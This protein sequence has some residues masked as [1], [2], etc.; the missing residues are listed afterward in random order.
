MPMPMPM[1]MPTSDALRA[2]VAPLA[3]TGLGPP[4]AADAPSPS[5]VPLYRQIKNLIIRGLQAGDWAPGAA[6][7]SESEL[8]SRYKVS[9]GT[10]RKAIDELASDNLLVRRQGKGTFVASHAE[11]TTQYRFL[12]LTADN[13][14]KAVLQRR[15]IGCARERAPSDVARPLG[16]RSGEAVVHVRRLLLADARPVVLDE[17]FLPGGAFKGLTGARLQAW[18]GPMYR[19][20]EAEFGVTMVRA[21]EQIR[22]VAAGASQALDLAV[23]PGA[24]LLSVE[25]LAYSYGG[26]PMELRRGLYLTDGYHYRNELS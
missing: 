20:F 14:Q 13:G 24:P 12:R 8:A 25:R 11:Q 17:I 4:S 21:Q 19:L 23:A 9:Q 5:F 2:D 1:P 26:R 7:P 10:V 16:L 22:A 6:I 18:T 15:L 3:A